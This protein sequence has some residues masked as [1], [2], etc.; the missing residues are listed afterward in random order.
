MKRKQDDEEYQ[1]K[2]AEVLKRISDPNISESVLIEVFIS[3]KDFTGRL[4]ASGQ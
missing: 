1:R 4:L 3:A 2:L